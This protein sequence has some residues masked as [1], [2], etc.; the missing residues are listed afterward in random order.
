M[1][2]L[3][4][5]INGRFVESKTTIYK[6]VCDPSTGEIIAQV[7]CC[8]PEEVNAAVTAAR[9]AFPAWSAT[10]PAKRAQCFFRLRELIAAHFDELTMCVAK[11]NGKAL[12]GIYD[13]AAKLHLTDSLW[14][15]ILINAGFNQAFAVWVLWGTFEAISIG[16]EEA[17][18]IDGCNR[19]Q[20][21]SRVV[22][23]L[24]APGIVTAL[25]FVFIN[26]WNEY[27]LAFVLI[28]SEEKKPLTVGINAF[29]GYTNVKWWYLFAVCLV[30]AIPVI[31][32]FSIIEKRLVS[33]MTAGAEKG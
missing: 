9:D 25:I 6:E 31:I 10:P 11:E 18:M 20:A 30:A 12:V 4:L 2:R 32:L 16:L 7:P 17:A 29:F 13:L 3:K 33:G 15:L 24:A 1:E 5:F 27:T 26:G 14:G 22:L 28:A 23:P 8:T 19:F 21:L